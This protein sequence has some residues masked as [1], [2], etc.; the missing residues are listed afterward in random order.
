MKILHLGKYYPPYFG[1][2]ER[3]NFDLVEELNK[4]GIE[5]DVLCFNDRANDLIE[6]KQYKIFRANNLFTAFSTPFS[7]SY[8]RIFK[9]IHHQYDIVHIHLPNPG[10]TLALQSVSFKG[11]IV[12]HWHSDIIKQKILKRFYAPF[13]KALLKRADS[14]VVTSPPYLEGSKDLMPFRHKCLVIPL[15]INKHEF[16]SDEDFF[17]SLR[18]SYAGKKIIFSL[19]RLIYY[20][21]FSYLVEA[22]KD[23][24]D[25][26]IILIGG[27]G[28]MENELQNLIHEQRLDSKV[29]LIGKIRGDDL[30]SYFQLCDVFCLPSIEKSEAFGLV[31]IEAMSFGKP[32]VS[33]NI[34]ESGVPWINENG[35]T[36]ITVNPKSPAE[37]SQAIK[38]IVTDLSLSKKLGENGRLKY[39]SEFTVGRMTDK[40]IELYRKLLRK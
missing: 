26:Y 39:Q 23:L 30:G 7:L 35:K 19:G 14:I 3:V 16:S 2:I 6:E 20:K 33:T 28:E 17:N 13:Q 29:K 1:G 21:G 22:A 31:Q 9:K 34:A 18:E 8:I 12:V 11:K 24:P 5:T 37:L 27:T 10:A 36:G 25:N 40:T 38:T 4:C 15:G 32:I